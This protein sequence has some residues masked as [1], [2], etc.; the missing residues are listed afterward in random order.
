MSDAL[1]I[2]YSWRDHKAV[3]D[4]MERARKDLNRGNGQV[5]K[6]A[7]WALART[8]GTSTRVAPKYRSIMPIPI[9]GFKKANRVEGMKPFNVHFDRGANSYNKLYWKKNI[10][11]VKKGPANI[12]LAGLAKAVWGR[13]IAK[14]GKSQDT[15]GVTDKALKKAPEKLRRGGAQGRRSVYRNRN[16]AGRP[17]FGASD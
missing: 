17:L 16:G 11:D 4:Q 2:E 8:L 5:L 1:K 15:K 10:S 13:S 12:R 9:R 14:L 6:M 3:L 7:A